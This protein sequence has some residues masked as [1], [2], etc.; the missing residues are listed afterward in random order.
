MLL[1]DSLV[2]GPLLGLLI[3]APLPC[4]L[5]TSVGAESATMPAMVRH[6]I[7]LGTVACLAALPLRAKTLTPRELPILPRDPKQQTPM[8]IPGYM[9]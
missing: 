4:L 6:R 7:A 5:G 3:K 8:H 1:F 9:G 2:P